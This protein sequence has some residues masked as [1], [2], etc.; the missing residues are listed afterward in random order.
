MSTKFVVKEIGTEHLPDPENPDGLS[1]EGKSISL[2]ITTEELERL[3][4]LYDPASAT[5][6][7]AADCRPL[8]RAILDAVL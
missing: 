6:P 7:L 4:S 8:V 3:L 1:L 5:S 2:F